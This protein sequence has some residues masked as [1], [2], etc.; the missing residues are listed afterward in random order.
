MQTFSKKLMN[1]VNE[2]SLI[3]KAHDSKKLTKFVGHESIKKDSCDSDY[4]R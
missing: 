1:W 2:Q 3:T 4:K